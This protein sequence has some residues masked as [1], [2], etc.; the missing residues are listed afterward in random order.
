MNFKILKEDGK[1]RFGLLEFEKGAVQTPAFMPVGT[2]G[3]VKAL[4]NSDVLSVGAEI[5]L[6]N[7]FH[8]YLRP[9]HELIKR[10]GGLHGFMNWQKPILTDSGGYQV[11]SLSPLRKI[12][13]EGVYFKS[14]L[15][16][17]AH[18]IGPKESM[19]IQDALNS[20]IVMAFDE[21]PPYP[22][23]YEYTLQ[24]LELTTRWANICKEVLPS[25]KT[26]FG[27]IQGGFYKELRIESARQIKD[28]G[29]DGYAVGGVSVGEPKELM[30]D[31][32]N[33][34]ACELPH[35][36][37]RYL[38]GVGF[39]EDILEAVGA[40]FD[41]FDCVIPTRTARHGTLFT[42]QGRISIKKQEF[43]EDF[44]PIDLDCSC[45][46]CKNYTKAYLNHLYKTGEI[47]S[48]RLNSIHNLHFYF[49]FFNKM[50]IA[51]TNGTFL[52]FKNKYLS[53][54]K[55]L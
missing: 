33:Q 37:P 55:P 40:G 44:S 31:M 11:F 38:M 4:S 49:D 39:P 43:K 7:T 53:T 17:S 30:H 6:C 24:S 21:C 41:M 8:L 12:K 50:A 51:I 46:T 32:I 35:D 42:S 28:I 2:Q 18:F 26:L 25:Q 14:H 15:D 5:I 27:I 16:G 19:A 10:A 9:G 22:S 54:V 48:T 23:T 13:E 45:Y 1:A 36:K 34:T 29:F 47:L 3:T 52:E 20:D